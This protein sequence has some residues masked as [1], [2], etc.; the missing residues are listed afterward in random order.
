MIFSNL[1]ILASLIPLSAAAAAS[2]NIKGLLQ[3]RSNQWSAETTVYFPGDSQ[4]TNETLRWNEYSAPTFLAVIRPGSQQDVQK[5]VKI[6]TSN[7][8]PFLATGGRHGYGTQFGRLQNGLEIDMSSFKTVQVDKDNNTLTVGGAVHFGDIVDPLYAA[9]KEIQTGSA[10]CVGLVGAS[11]GGG[12]GRYQGFH[13][14]ILDALLSLRMVTAAGDIIDVSETSNSDLFWAM[15]GAGTNFGVILSATYK[16][17]DL[18][19]GG[20]VMNADM[21]FPGS[22]NASFFEMIQ[23]MQ[24]KIP[25]ELSLIASMAYNATS[26]T[27]EIIANFV[28]IGPEDDGR[29]VIKPFLNLSPMV[30]EI[31]TVPWNQLLSKAAFG[32]TALECIK[33]N[34]HSMFGVNVRNISA[35]TYIDVFEKMTDFWTRENAA[36]GS[37]F[38]I[39][40]FSNAAMVAVPQD[41]TA[42]PWRDTKAYL[43]LQMTW[44]NA[45]AADSANHLAKQLR[46]Q[47]VNTSGYP[48]H[49]VYVSYAHG[50]EPLASKFGASKLPRLAEMKKRWD[51]SNVF[52]YGASL[53]EQYP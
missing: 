28:Y 27:P 25:K 38:S 40:F 1:A 3:D 46:S 24:D 15:R 23:G 14:L 36:Q 18:T 41:A 34:Q 26:K 42:Y 39:E 22:A 33:G 45:D 37:S 21:I 31:S 51:P 12:I 47:L 29:K 7:N 53:P 48:Q 50:D 2:A 6:A 10:T 35:S 16:V 13:G 19:H 32:A 9:G 52:A 17:S 44:T 8:V 49:S 4:F 20:Q 30:Q 5:V 43:M 11:L